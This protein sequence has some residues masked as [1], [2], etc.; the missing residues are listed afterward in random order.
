MNAFDLAILRYVNQFPQHSWLLDKGMGFVSHNNLF[1]GGIFTM[2]LWWAWFKQE[3]RPSHHRAQI[4]STL[5]SG[6]V[7]IAVARALALLLPFRVRPL[8][9]A[10]VHFVL[11]YGRMPDWFEGWSSFPSDHAVLFF[12][13]ATGLFLLHRTIGIFALVYSLVF[14]A[15]PRV[16]VGIHYPTDIL[17]GALIGIVIALLGNHYL[18]KNKHIRSL[19]TLS[20]VKP[21]LFYPVFFLFTYQIADLFDSSRELVRGMFKLIQG[22]IA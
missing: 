3:K 5:L 21:E 9:E 22:M 15:A 20:Y 7:A 1:K 16:Y 17:A 2:L 10:S 13:L 19:V 4:I 11:P 18:V 14:I 8:Q 12:T 6:V